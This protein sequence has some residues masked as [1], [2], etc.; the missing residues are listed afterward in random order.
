MAQ[1]T[2]ANPTAI[3]EEVLHLQVAAFAGR[4]ADESV[5]VSRSLAGVDG[6]ELV[7]DLGAEEQADA[8]QQRN[9][10]GDLVNFFAIVRQGEVQ[11]RP[12]QSEPC[13][14]LADVPHLG[15]GGAQEL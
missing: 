8:I 14:D 11:T 7:L 10:A 9:V 2:V 1:A 13:E 15:A 3:E 6:V 12:C 5:E 4:I